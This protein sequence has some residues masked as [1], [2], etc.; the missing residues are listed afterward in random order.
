MFFDDSIH[1][2]VHHFSFPET[3]EF[4]IQFA[5]SR[6]FPLKEVI[7]DDILGHFLLKVSL[8]FT[9]LGHLG[10]NL[11]FILII[12]IEIDIVFLSFLYLDEIPSLKFLNNLHQVLHQKSILFVKIINLRKQ[13]VNL[14]I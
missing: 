14:S 10:N 7:F 1:F 4:I 8:E 5:K 3:G 9:L 2:K 11:S 12:N 6:I 13:G